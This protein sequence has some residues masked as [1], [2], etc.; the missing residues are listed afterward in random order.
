M[1]FLVKVNQ[2]VI[3]VFYPLFKMRVKVVSVNMKNGTL[4]MIFLAI[5]LISIIKVVKILILFSE[6]SHLKYNGGALMS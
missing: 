5:S 6:E 4:K 1:F 2:K 3:N